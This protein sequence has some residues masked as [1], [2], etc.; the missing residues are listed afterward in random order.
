MRPEADQQERADAGHFPEHHQQQQVARQH[1]AQH[2]AHEQQQVA[3]EAVRVVLL[4][5]VVARVQHHQRA[6][7]QH[8]PGEHPGQPV[9]PQREGQPDLRQPLPETA[10]DPAIQDA[11]GHRCQQRQTAHG[12][13]G[14]HPGGGSAGAAA[15]HGHGHRQQEG[16]GKQQ[17]KAGIHA[18]NARFTSRPFSLTGGDLSRKDSITP[19]IAGNVRDSFYLSPGRRPFGY[20]PSRMER[21]G[22]SAQCAVRRP[23]GPAM[24]GAAH[25]A[26]ASRT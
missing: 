9:Q 11:G 12:G 3:V 16:Q 24:T 15:E 5:Q 14:G 7:A 22:L 19:S 20:V 13:G 10:Q 18:G 6:D 23:V 8:H 4:A 26:T 21:S 17:E 1:H 2:G 25:Y